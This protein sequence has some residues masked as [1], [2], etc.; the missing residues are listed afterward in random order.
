M[1]NSTLA[2]NHNIK[3]MGKICNSSFVFSIFSLYSANHRY[4]L[5]CLPAHWE[6]EN[7]FV[8]ILGLV[9]ESQ[10]FVYVLEA[11]K[12]AD[13]L[14][15]VITP[16]RCTLVDGESKVTKLSAIQIMET[17]KINFEKTCVH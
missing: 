11:K 14:S 4:V 13:N 16:I 10:P 9:S 15:F 3:A 6:F 17:K 2:I 7:L 8:F 12:F 5:L 1:H